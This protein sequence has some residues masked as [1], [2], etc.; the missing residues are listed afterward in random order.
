MVISFPLGLIVLDT[1]FFIACCCFGLI[2]LFDFVWLLVWLRRRLG[3]VLL[4]VQIAGCF[5]V[6]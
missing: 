4:L 6:V 1:W 5:L 3:Y 2:V